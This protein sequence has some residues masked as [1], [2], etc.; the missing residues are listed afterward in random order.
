MERQ[1]RGT[2]DYIIVL[3]SKRNWYCLY[4][5]EQGYDTVRIRS[6]DKKASKCISHSQQ[7]WLDALHCLSVSS[8]SSR[9]Q[10]QGKL[11]H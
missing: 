9:I 5:Q 3:K 1:M 10:G 6:S 4:A 8:I 11:N 7:L 2:S